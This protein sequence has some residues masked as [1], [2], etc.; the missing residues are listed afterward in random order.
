[1]ICGEKRTS[2]CGA[3]THVCN[4]DAGHEPPHGVR[5]YPTS[6]PFITWPHEWTAEDAARQHERYATWAK[7][8][9]RREYQSASQAKAMLEHQNAVANL[10]KARGTT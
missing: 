2:S 7:K 5:E 3:P 4:L 8:H 10:R 9:V 6:R 1:M